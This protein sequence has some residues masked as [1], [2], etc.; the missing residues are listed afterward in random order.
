MLDQPTTEFAPNAELDAVLANFQPTQPIIAEATSTTPGQPSEMQLQPQEAPVEETEVE[1][2]EEDAGV[3]DANDPGFVEAFK[4]HFGVEPQEAIDTFNQLTA[5]RD[6]MTLMG[7]WN[8]SPTQYQ[9]RMG[10]VREF[11]ETLP[12]EGKPQFNNV[13]GAIAIWNHI[14]GQQPAQKKTTLSRPSR[15]ASAKQPAV[16]VVKKSD[17][18]RM[19]NKEYV[20]NAARI[21]KAV[22]EGRF[23]EDV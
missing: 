15:S 12:E 20:A 3:E 6:E 9:E 22:L 7:Q 10:K 4:Q 5:F 18:L 23:V 13:D 14:S 21:Q 19:N 11:Y 1:S 2:N 16:D 8:L 17:V